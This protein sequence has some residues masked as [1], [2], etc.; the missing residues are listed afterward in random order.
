MTFL[1]NMEKLITFIYSNETRWIFNFDEKD[2]HTIKN[3]EIME[4]INNNYLETEIS[5][6]EWEREKHIARIAWFVMNGWNDPITLNF[7][8]VCMWPIID[9]NHRFIAAKFKK[10]KSILAN[11]TGSLE[12]LIDLMKDKDKNK[13]MERCIINKTENREK[14][15][16]Y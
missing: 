14:N 3:E 11:A 15:E 5:Q 4:A 6:A 10:Q 16:K 8:M 2:S 12:T 9:G 7:D 1:Y 13:I